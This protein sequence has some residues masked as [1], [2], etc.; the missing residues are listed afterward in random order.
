MA[1]HVGLMNW[2]ALLG[3][4]TNAER[5]VKFD[6]RIPEGRSAFAQ[7]PWPQAPSFLECLPG[8]SKK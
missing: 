1:C 4:A 7:I 8:L 2:S 5:Y 3:V 6:S